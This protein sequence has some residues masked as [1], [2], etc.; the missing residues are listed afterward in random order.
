[1]LPP[2][3]QASVQQP[4]KAL[5]LP[6]APAASMDSPASSAAAE[7]TQ[8]ARRRLERAAREGLPVKGYAASWE[9]ARPKVLEGDQVADKVGAGWC[10]ESCCTDSG[11]LC[12]C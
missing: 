11:L 1:M 7:D 2:P 6:L 10:I 5:E 12:G 4:P 9:A 8:T 3:P